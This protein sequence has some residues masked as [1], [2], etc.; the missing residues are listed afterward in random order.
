MNSLADLRAAAQER[1]I[2]QSGKIV[3]VDRDNFPKLNISRQV[4]K[5]V[6]RVRSRK[7]RHS[8]PLVSQ[9]DR[10]MKLSRHNLLSGY[11][12]SCLKYLNKVCLRF[13]KIAS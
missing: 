9:W 1:A 11:G 7:T 2:G 13:Q 12:T 4:V 8:E 10:K 5:I 6:Y 3:I